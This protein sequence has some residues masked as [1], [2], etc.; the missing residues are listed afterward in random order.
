MVILAARTGCGKTALAINLLTHV[1]GIEGKPT[2]IFSLEMSQELICNRIFSSQCDVSLSRF[3]SG[4]FD[5]DEWR[6]IYEYG[7][8]FKQLPLRINDQAGLRPTQFRERARVWKQQHDV[9]FLVLDYLQLMDP[10]RRSDKRER[11]VAEASKLI[12]Q[13]AVELGIPILVLCQLNREAD[14]T[15]KPLLSQLRESGAIE[16]DA[17]IILFIH[18]WQQDPSQRNV[19][20]DMSVGKSRNS[21]T[22][23][24]RL[25]YEK[26]FTRFLPYFG[27]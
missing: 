20:V 11:E 22:G 5:Y 21:A 19:V 1:A 25:L 9:Q 6:R 8:T 13:T 4:R 17:D 27:E 23:G 15:G 14:K 26:P 16:Q 24:F 7:D 3:R 12:K 2:G 10:D 18:P